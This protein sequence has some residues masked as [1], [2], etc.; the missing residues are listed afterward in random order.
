MTST[1]RTSIPGNERRQG[2]GR[3]EGLDVVGLSLRG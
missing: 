3:E 2:V 1:N